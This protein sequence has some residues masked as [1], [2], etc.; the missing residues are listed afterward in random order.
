MYED[1]PVNR[2]DVL[3]GFEY[4]ENGGLVCTD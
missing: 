1:L 4:P 2:E 3:L